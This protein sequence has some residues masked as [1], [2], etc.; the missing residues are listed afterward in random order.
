VNPGS[1]FRHPAQE[2]HRVGPF[3]ALLAASSDSDELESAADA[4]TSTETSPGKHR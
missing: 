1:V 2:G 4:G 3:L